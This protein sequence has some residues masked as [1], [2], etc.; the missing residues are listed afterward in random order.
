MSGAVVYDDRGEA[1]WHAPGGA[2]VALDAQGSRVDWA[3]K[4][5]RGVLVDGDRRTPTVWA[6]AVEVL[7]VPGVSQSLL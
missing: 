1:W 2:V 7:G 4:I 5:V 6:M 3:R